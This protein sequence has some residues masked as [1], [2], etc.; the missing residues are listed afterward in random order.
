MRSPET[1][2]S[3]IPDARVLGVLP[4]INHARFII[5]ISIPFLRCFADTH[6]DRRGRR[7]SLR[8]IPIQI[9]F[10]LDTSGH[11]DLDHESI[12]EDIDLLSCLMKQVS[13]NQL[14]Q[15]SFLIHTGNNASSLKRDHRTESQRRKSH[16]FQHARHDQA[17]HRG[18]PGERSHQAGYLYKPLARFPRKINSPKAKGSLFVGGLQGTPA[19]TPLNSSYFV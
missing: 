2:A 18:G 19:A 13:L 14:A 15:F 8:Q 1:L 11:I 6:L 10:N 9:G 12:L 5:T 3:P 16:S 7:V 4:P 17:A